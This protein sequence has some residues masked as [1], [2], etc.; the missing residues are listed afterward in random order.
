L[1]G[2]PV[3]GNVILNEP[4]ISFNG[5]GTGDTSKSPPGQKKRVSFQNWK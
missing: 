3:I 1:N 2:S 4:E 5:T